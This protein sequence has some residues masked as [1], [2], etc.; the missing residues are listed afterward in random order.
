MP[1]TP[2]REVR[3]WSWVPSKV[4]A[5]VPGRQW[6]EEFLIWRR[7][8]SARAPTRCLAPRIHKEDRGTR[9]LGC[10]PG[11][12]GDFYN[13]R[14]GKRT[15]M[16][17]LAM[18]SIA[19]HR[20]FITVVHLVCFHCHFTQ[21]QSSHDILEIKQRRYKSRRSGAISK[22]SLNVDSCFTCQ[23]LPIGFNFPLLSKGPPKLI[24]V[25]TS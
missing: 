4:V 15:S 18:T 17:F 5:K 24:I 14:Q 19:Q 7:C 6:C 25:L 20:A 12:S 22:E 2:R 1:S 16:K 21:K 13:Q 10:F 9:T 23:Y 8:G 3:R 11:R